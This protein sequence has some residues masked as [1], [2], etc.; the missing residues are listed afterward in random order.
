MFVKDFSQSWPYGMQYEAER[1]FVHCYFR[2]S[3]ATGVKSYIHRMLPRH[4]HRLLK[5]DQEATEE[6]FMN[7]CTHESTQRIVQLSCI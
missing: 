3:F 1:V 2:L 5:P 6:L 4:I 7:E